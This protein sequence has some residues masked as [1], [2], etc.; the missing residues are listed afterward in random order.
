MG[1][2]GWRVVPREGFGGGSWVCHAFVGAEFFFA[3]E[4]GHEGFVFGG[5]GEVSLLLVCSR[6]NE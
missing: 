2:G 6:G 5:L 1:S 3:A 4:A